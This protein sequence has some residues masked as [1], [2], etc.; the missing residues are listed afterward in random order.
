LQNNIDSDTPK[1]LVRVPARLLQQSRNAFTFHIE[2]VDTTAP[3][4]GKENSGNEIAPSWKVATIATQASA[5]LMP[6]DVAKVLWNVEKAPVK[7]LRWE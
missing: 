3:A 4:G 5:D 2:D 1:P 6:D 7:V